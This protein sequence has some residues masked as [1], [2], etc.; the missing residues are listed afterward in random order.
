MGF[1]RKLASLPKAPKGALTRTFTT[2]KAEA[3]TPDS[4]PTPSSQ[5]LGGNLESLTGSACKAVE[6]PLARQQYRRAIT[7]KSYLRLC[8]CP[9]K[10]VYQES[11]TTGAAHKP[12]E[13]ATLLHAGPH[14]RLVPGS[15]LPASISQYS[16][17]TRL[18]LLGWSK[19][20]VRGP[21]VCTLAARPDFGY[22]LKRLLLRK[23]QVNH[24]LQQQDRRLQHLAFASS[25]QC[26][27]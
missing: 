19:L 9:H 24:A 12:E 5:D 18:D 25:H 16:W 26:P 11:A 6:A 3:P 1:L 22:C 17:L 2:Q 23:Q 14:L 13:A 8:L 15:S 27:S 10:S 7:T 21:V 4:P 20:Q